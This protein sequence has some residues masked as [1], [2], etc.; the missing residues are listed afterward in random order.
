MQ[1]RVADAVDLFGNFT[2]LDRD[3]SSWVKHYARL[4][5]SDPRLK[6]RVL[7][8]GC[9][10]SGAWQE[11]FR[12]CVNQASQLDGIDPNPRVSE[13]PYVKQRWCGT[14]ESVDIPAETYDAAASFQVVEHVQDPRGFMRAIFR[15]LKPGGVFYA[16]TPHSQHP[17][18]WGVKALELINLKAFAGGKNEGINKIPTYYRLNSRKALLRAT[19]GLGFESLELHY[20]PCVQW[21]QYVPRALR[22]IPHLYDRLIG[23]RGRRFA[24][25]LMFKIEKP[26]GASAL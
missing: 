2:E 7:D 17:F 11:M 6:K 9:G 20:F 19:E 10:P 5:G 23:I 14:L 1:V 24:Q 15:L 13:N 22:V 16:T 21:D 26:A 25:M 18:A 3:R 12:T 4:I 8:V